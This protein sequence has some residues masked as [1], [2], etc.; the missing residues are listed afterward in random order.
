MKPTTTPAAD[1]RVAFDCPSNAA[2]TA[3][4]RILV[5]DFE[6]V[7]V[8]NAPRRGMNCKS[9]EA[10]FSI[11]DIEEKAENLFRGLL[12]IATELEEYISP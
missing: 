4:L 8:Q 2:G 7:H 3:V 6:V 9:D 1:K 10:I 5:S 11:L 12:G